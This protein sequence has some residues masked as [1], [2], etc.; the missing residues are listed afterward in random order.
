MIKIAWICTFSNQTIRDHIEVGISYI[1]Q[2]VRKITDKEASCETADVGIWNTN[3]FAE[4]RKYESIELHVICPYSYLKHYHQDFVIDGIYYHFFR[5]EAV[6]LSTL[7]LKRFQNSPYTYPRNRK[8][9]SRLLKDINPDIIHLIGAENAFYSLSVLDIPKGGAKVIAHL[10]TLVSDPDFEKNY[11]ISKKGYNELINTEKLVLT[12]ADYIGTRIIPFK[13]IILQSVKPDANFLDFTLAVAENVNRSTEAK[14]FDFVYFAIDISKAA[15]WA[16]KAF[17]IANKY[18]PKLTLNI[19][20]GYTPDYKKS[21]DILIEKSGLSGK[22]YFSGKQPSH[23]DV[24][25]Q[26]RKSKYALLPLKIDFITGTIREAMAN[27]LPVVTTITPGTPSLNQEKECVLL[28]AKEDFQE[29]ANNMMKLI[30]DPSFT[31][32]LISNSLEKSSNIISNADVV[33]KYVECYQKILDKSN[34]NLKDIH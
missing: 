20:G 26:I 28:S 12:R 6:Y 7:L 17:A 4:F 22:V 18:Y 21:I 13:D 30:E 9:I 24:M 25:R 27:G 8:N 14:E 19:V 16:I 34:N 31:E 33:R 23:E 10:Q 32:T 3:A 5:N 11:P 2:M 29:M 1:E 15:D